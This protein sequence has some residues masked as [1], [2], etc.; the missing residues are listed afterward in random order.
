M[1][2]EHTLTLETKECI[3]LIA[4]A[5]SIP[6]DDVKSLRYNFAIKNHSAEEIAEKLEEIQK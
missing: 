4:H 5:L 1:K 2:E 6:E 3:V